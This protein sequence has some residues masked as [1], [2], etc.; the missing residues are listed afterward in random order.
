MPA[1]VGSI[2]EL[3][4][5]RRRQRKPAADALL[6]WTRASPEGADCIAR[7]AGQRTRS[8]RWRCGVFH[9]RIVRSGIERRRSTAGNRS[10]SFF[11]AYLQ[12]PLKRRGE[13]RASPPPV[14]CLSLEV[15]VL[16]IVVRI[17]VGLVE[18]TGARVD[19]VPCDPM[20]HGARWRHTLPDEEVIDPEDET[21]DGRITEGG[22]GISKEDVKPLVTA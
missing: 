20:A 1:T 11:E 8:D 4:R 15:T 17:A 5:A 10:A 2:G 21:V 6:M 13:A 19:D 3:R 22:V 9:E 18:C 12:G 14:L 16:R 7:R